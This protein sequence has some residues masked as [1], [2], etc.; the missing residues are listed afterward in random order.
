MSYFNHKQLKKYGKDLPQLDPTR[1]PSR[2]WKI[3]MGIIF[4]PIGAFL[5]PA[6]L[7]LLWT[8]AVPIFI[9]VCIWTAYAIWVN[10]K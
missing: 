2:L 5:F 3:C 1:E 4:V 10:N 8:L 9:A 7:I 6:A